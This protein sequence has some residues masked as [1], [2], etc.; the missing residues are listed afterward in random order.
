MPQYC[1]IF[2]A[3]NSAI[4][5]SILMELHIR[6]QETTSYKKSTQNSGFGYVQVVCHNWAKKG[7]NMG[8]AVPRALVGGWGS[9]PPQKFVHG[10]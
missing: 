6:V 2:L 9:G 8:M 1:Y 5:F 10:S 7:P 3:H 4:F